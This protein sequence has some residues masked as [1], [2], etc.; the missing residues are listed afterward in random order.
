VGIEWFVE[1]DVDREAWSDD[2]FSISPE[3]A[4]ELSKSPELLLQWVKPVETVKLD[5]IEDSD[6][7]RNWMT[8]GKDLGK[9]NF[10]A[11]S[12]CSFV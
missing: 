3:E 4:I 1:D 8:C 9:K 2:E 6:F 10:W 12:D 7:E 5:R 11:F